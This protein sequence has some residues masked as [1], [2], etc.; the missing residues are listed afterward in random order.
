MTLFQRPSWSSAR[1]R[2]ACWETR[3]TAPMA[4]A[5]FWPRLS[6]SQSFP[7]R[8]HG[9]TRR[10]TTR[11][12]TRH[13]RR[14]SAPSTSSNRHGGSRLAT[15][16]RCATT[17]PSSLLDAPCSGCE[18]RNQ[19]SA[20][21]AAANLRHRPRVRSCSRS[22]SRAH[23]SCSDWIHLTS[24]ATTLMQS[25]WVCSR[26]ERS[27]APRWCS[28]VSAASSSL[29]DPLAIRRHL[30]RSSPSRPFPSAMFSTTDADARRA[31]SLTLA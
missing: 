20:P 9:L 31:W 13:A 23:E 5:R 29:A 4:F 14:S 7:P 28:R 12:S 22:R 18:S 25:W 10:S 16:R 15:R 17:P 30:A 3:R 6:A 11:S 8:V 21:Y 19:N 24:I 1:N 26:A 27:S 2:S